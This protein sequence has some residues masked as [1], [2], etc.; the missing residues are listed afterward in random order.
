MTCHTLWW[1]VHTP[2]IPEAPNAH[3][4]N[5]NPT[6]SFKV[7]QVEVPKWPCIGC[8]SHPDR[9]SENPLSIPHSKVQSDNLGHDYSGKLNKFECLMIVLLGRTPIF[10]WWFYLRMFAWIGT[11]DKGYPPF[12][13]STW[14]NTCLPVT[15]EV[16]IS[17]KDRAKQMISM[18]KG[19]IMANICFRWL[20]LDY[21]SHPRDELR[22]IELPL[23]Q[24]HKR[25][26][27]PC[28]LVRKRIITAGRLSLLAYLSLNGSPGLR[29][30][31]AT[32]S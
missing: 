28:L 5:S 9:T 10:R 13:L 12:D 15:T 20:R 21:I 2:C 17:N 24:H 26:G 1:S 11:R 23:N 27:Q 30:A 18:D 16:S 29:Y 4:P 22:K 25:H 19:R 8:S 6:I 3:F 14:A 32:H 31:L 7:L